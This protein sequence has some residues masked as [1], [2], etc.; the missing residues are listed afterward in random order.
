MYMALYTCTCV[1]RVWCTNQPDCVQIGRCDIWCY[2]FTPPLKTHKI[3]K[4]FC[5]LLEFRILHIDTKFP[6]MVN[7]SIYGN[8][9]SNLI[10]STPHLWASVERCE[11]YLQE[12]NCFT[13]SWASLASL[14]PLSTWSFNVPTSRLLKCPQMPVLLKLLWGFSHSVMMCI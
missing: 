5:S 7:D 1:R 4:I 13:N 11:V 9:Q 10:Q 3:K 12:L 8:H 2:F 6:Y 14:P